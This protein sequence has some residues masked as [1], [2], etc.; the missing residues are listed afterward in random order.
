MVIRQGASSIPSS[1]KKARARI[2]CVRSKEAALV[3]QGGKREEMKQ[4]GSKA[5]GGDKKG[6]MGVKNVVTGRP[7]FFMPSLLIFCVCQ[8]L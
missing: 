6:T 4:A 3:V 2:W 1:K 7:K 5:S 8:C